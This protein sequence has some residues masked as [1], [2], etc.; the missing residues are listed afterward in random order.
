MDQYHVVQAF[1]TYVRGGKLLGQAATTVTSTRKPSSGSPFVGEL[2]ARSPLARQVREEV[3]SFREVLEDLATRIRTMEF[4]DMIGL[5]DFLGEVEGQLD[6]LTDEGRVLKHFPDWPQRLG[7]MREAV[8][9]HREL[10]GMVRRFKAWPTGIRAATED[11][12][13]MEKYTRTTIARVDKL[14]QQEGEV[15][16]RFGKARLPWKKGIWREVRLAALD[17]LAVYL[18]L[19]M[20]QA[21]KDLPASTRAELLQG[22]ITYSYTMHAFVGGLC[23]RC[24]PLFGE[25]ID[26][27][28]QHLTPLH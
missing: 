25:L 24:R 9:L 6:L 5:V 10:M 16:E 4:R 28:E 13:A 11:L 27:A 17:I 3:V 15:A 18:P 1:Q 19:A 2:E 12:I 23:P 22:A 7:T 14:Q 20:A 26:M 21:Q 8:K